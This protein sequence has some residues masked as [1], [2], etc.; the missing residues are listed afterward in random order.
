MMFDAKRT[1]SCQCRFLATDFLTLPLINSF[2]KS[3]AFIFREKS[4]RRK[5]FQIF[6]QEWNWNM[7]KFSSSLWRNGNTMET[8]LQSME[9]NNTKLLYIG[10]LPES[11]RKSLLSPA[12]DLPPVSQK[13]QVNNNTHLCVFLSQWSHI[14]KYPSFFFF[15]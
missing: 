7:L 2:S 6:V 8:F 12:R 15:F 4:F 10:R 3:F 13:P 11:H 9:A 14:P 5:V 1:D